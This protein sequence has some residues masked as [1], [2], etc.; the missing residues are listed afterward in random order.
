MRKTVSYH[1]ILC[2][3][4]WQTETLEANF[5]LAWHLH[6]HLVGVHWLWPS[7]CFQM[8]NA[9]I[10]QELAI[11]KNC[12]CSEQV[13]TNDLG[14]HP[15]HRSDNC[16]LVD[17]ASFGGVMVVNNVNQDEAVSRSQRN[18]TCA[19]QNCGYC[20]FRE[21]M[22]MASTQWKGT[23]AASAISCEGW[24]NC[25]FV[26]STCFN[27]PGRDGKWRY[28]KPQRLNKV[29]IYIYMGQL[30]GYIGTIPPILSIMRVFIVVVFLTDSLG[31][32]SWPSDSQS[33]HEIRIGYLQ[34]YYIILYLWYP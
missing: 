5:I 6:L 15:M 22:R 10:L 32:S 34:G 19:L 30:K 3:P 29:C 18:V 4:L 8:D 17:W 14:P 20:K 33:I 27:I 24:A 2:C 23:W 31:S 1:E 9:F 7:A 21:I 25:A 28:L 16:R 26:K 12:G 13:W 11:L